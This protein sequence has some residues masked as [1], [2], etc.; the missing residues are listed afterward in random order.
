MRNTPI[1]QTAAVWAEDVGF[2]GLGV[3]NFQS[4]VTDRG[5]IWRQPTAHDHS[6]YLLDCSGLLHMDLVWEPQVA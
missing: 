1:A 5:R 4:L 6:T 3:E 2:R